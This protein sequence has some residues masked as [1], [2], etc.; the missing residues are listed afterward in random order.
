[1]SQVSFKAE[2][3]DTTWYHSTT[4][5]GKSVP[6]MKILSYKY[7]SI[8]LLA[9]D[10]KLECQALMNIER[11]SRIWWWS[12]AL[13]MPQKSPARRFEFWVMEAFQVTPQKKSFW[14]AFK[15][16]REKKWETWMHS[17]SVAIINATSH[18]SLF[19]AWGTLYDGH[20][21]VYLIFRHPMSIP[22]S[23]SEI[24]WNISKDRL[25]GWITIW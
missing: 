20:L 21:R 3:S 9:T 14:E 8:S 16:R 18:F 5:R 13:R 22:L 23:R 7:M 4:S 1:M 11:V 6:T 12:F 17:K 24:S 15:V 19:A 2:V 25:S 10:W